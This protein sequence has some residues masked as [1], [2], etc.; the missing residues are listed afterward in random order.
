MKDVE[1]L[2]IV[3]ERFFLPTLGTGVYKAMLCSVFASDV[4]SYVRIQLQGKNMAGDQ[5]L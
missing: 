1:L 5:M 4:F 3:F 2:V